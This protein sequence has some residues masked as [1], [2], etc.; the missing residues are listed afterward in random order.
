[1]LASVPTESFALAAVAALALGG[2]GLS[3]R[4]RDRTVQLTVDYGVFVVFGLSALAGVWL[5]LNRDQAFFRVLLERYWLVGLFLVFIL[6]G[7]MLL[8][9]APSES[10]VPVAILV[11]QQTDIASPTYT[12]WAII[13]GVATLG[14]T[15]GQ[16]LLFLLAKRWGR[17]RL[18]ERP[19]FR[20]SDEQLARF[21]GWFQRW[22]LLAVPVSNSLLFTRGM[23]TVP[24]GLSEMSD[25]RFL[26]VSALGTI[27]F[28]VLLAAAAV[29][30][31]ELGVLDGVFAVIATLG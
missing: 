24:A 3:A 19:W 4:A 25:Q 1:M 18:L 21:E 29:G 22:G 31:V 27:S 2:L 6:E 16:Y 15:I 7:A 26:A 28:E 13:I 23:L 17:E 14:A 11:T 20:I 9:F 12:T 5:F 10:L 8:Y 30:I